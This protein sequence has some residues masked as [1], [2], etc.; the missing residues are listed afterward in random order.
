MELCPGGQGVPAAAQGLGDTLQPLASGP[1]PTSEP[2]QAGRGIFSE[3]G[4]VPYFLAIGTQKTIHTIVV[5]GLEGHR[6]RV[7]C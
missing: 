3:S 6:H 5:L 2:G 7:E 1:G 4:A